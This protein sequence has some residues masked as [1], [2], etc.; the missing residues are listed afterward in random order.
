MPNPSVQHARIS[1]RDSE[2][3]IINGVVINADTINYLK[4]LI[5]DEPPSDRNFYVIGGIMD[6]VYY[7]MIGPDYQFKVQTDFLAELQNLYEF[8]YHLGK[9]HEKCKSLTV[10]DTVKVKKKAP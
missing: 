8:Y 4:K 2:V 7:Q 10:S 5:S 3:I 6:L 1:L 9:C